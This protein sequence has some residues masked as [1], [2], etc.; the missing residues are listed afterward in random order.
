MFRKFKRAF[1][2]SAFAFLLA[3]SCCWLPWLA[4]GLGGFSG[5]VGLSE[6]LMPYSGVFMAIGFG[7]LGLGIFQFRKSIPKK[8]SEQEALLFSILTCPICGFTK[9]EKMPT[10]ACQYF[11]E[12][13]N[14]KSMLKPK[15][16]DCCVFC[17][18]G[19]VPCP[20][21]QADKNCCK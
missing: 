15:G 10:N 4:L 9:E 8:S 13:N 14:C 17:S 18:Y 1:I 11:Y 19:T 16:T 3:S 7:F 21:M 2:G 12:C 5:L 6:G 20:P